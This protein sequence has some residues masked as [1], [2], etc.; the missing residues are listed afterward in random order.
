MPTNRFS[1]HRDNWITEDPGFR[2]R[3]SHLGPGSAV[4]ENTICNR[5]R[6]KRWE[7]TIK[8]K[9]MFGNYRFTHTA[10][11][12]DRYLSESTGSDPI[13][14]LMIGFGDGACLSSAMSPS[15]WCSSVRY[16]HHS[17]AVGSC[18]HCLYPTVQ[19]I[20]TVIPSTGFSNPLGGTGPFDL[21]VSDL[22]LPGNCG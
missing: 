20:N 11:P 8:Q 17:Y 18:R 22:P 14:E 1:F 21:G 7:K 6:L 9:N 13:Y 4:F 12:A 10:V 2:R 16:R 5:F 3:E 15:G 19:V